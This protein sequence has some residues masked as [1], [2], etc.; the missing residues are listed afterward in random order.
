MLLMHYLS[1]LMLLFLRTEFGQ[2]S[3]RQPSIR[4]VHGHWSNMAWPTTVD[5]T[6]HGEIVPRWARLYDSPGVV[7]WNEDQAVK[8]SEKPE[9]AAARRHTQ[10]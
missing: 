1:L 7:L 10:L 5:A 3:V 8:V 2:M 4:E 6:E 9:P